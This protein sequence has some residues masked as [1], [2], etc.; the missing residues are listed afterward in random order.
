VLTENAAPAIWSATL[1]HPERLVAKRGVGLPHANGI[2]HEKAVHWW[3]CRSER[4]S[5][6]TNCQTLVPYPVP[7]RLSND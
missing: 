7:L 3:R 2:P 5:P 4:K 6:Y 1:I